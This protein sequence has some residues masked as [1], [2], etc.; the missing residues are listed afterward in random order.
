M[1]VYLGIA[2]VATLL[3]SLQQNVSSKPLKVIFYCM[4]VCWLALFAGA[5]DLSVGT[6]TLVYGVPAAQIAA[7]SNFFDFYNGY[8]SN[9]APLIKIFYWV[10]ANATHSSFWVLFSIQVAIGAPALYSISR[11]GGKFAPLGVF[12]YVIMFYPMG[13]N[14][15]R[16]MIAMGFMLIA[17]HYASERKLPLFIIWLLI[18]CGFHT[19]LLVTFII[20][21]ITCFIQDAHLSTGLRISVVVVLSVIFCLFFSMGIDIFSSI[22]FYSNYFT[23]SRLNEGGS[24]RP[25]A[26]SALL[27]ITLASMASLLGAKYSDRNKA[28]LPLLSLVVLGLALLLLT[29]L[30]RYLYRVGIM[31]IYFLPALI[32]QLSLSVAEHNKRYFPLFLIITVALTIWWSFDFY[33]VQGNHQVIPYLLAGAAFRF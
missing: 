10:V 25:F 32:I 2:L 5:R 8:Y 13:F 14:M 27:V 17:F 3:S 19:S 22:G 18:G 16:Q 26:I 28:A 21:P 9:W 4:V 20:Y 7:S 6:D 31:F 1:L 12:A 23:D 15:M 30:S 29:L 33:L 11:D 24:I